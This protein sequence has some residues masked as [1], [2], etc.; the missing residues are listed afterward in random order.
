MRGVITCITLNAAF[1]KYQS[2]RPFVAVVGVL[3]RVGVV[4]KRKRLPA[5]RR[6]VFFTNGS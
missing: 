4:V 3:A 5:R 6:C 1:I 2:Y